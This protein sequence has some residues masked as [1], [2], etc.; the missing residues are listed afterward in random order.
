MSSNRN[1]IK[2]ANVS[3]W[4]IFALMTLT[5]FIMN[6]LFHYYAYG[7]LLFSSLWKE[8]LVFFEFYG[9]KFLIASALSSLV[10][11]FKRI[12]W[13]WLVV[14]IANVWIEANLLYFRNS[15]FFID[16]YS[17]LMAT[18]LQGYTSAASIY[19]QS[20]DWAFIVLT[21][22][23][24]L[25]TGL[26]N[27]ISPERKRLPWIALIIF[28]ISISLHSVLRYTQEKRLLDDDV[29]YR[30]N[31]FSHNTRKKT[32]QEIL[33]IKEHSILHAFFFDIVDLV[34][35]KKET[36]TL[37]EQDYQFIHQALGNTERG[38]EKA[39]RSLIVV[40]VE[41]FENW[42]L[43]ED[44]MPNLWQ[45]T[46]A[47]NVFYAPYAVSQIQQGTSSDGQLI[48]TTGLLPINEGATVFRFS[49]DSFPSFCQWYDKSI[50]VNPCGEIWNQKRMTNAYHYSDYVVWAEPQ[51]AYVIDS[52]ITLFSQ[53]SQ[54]SSMFVITSSTH[55]PF[56]VEGL[57]WTYPI[58]S[59][60][61]QTM[62]H[63]IQ[64]F[65]YLDESLKPLLDRVKNDAVFAN[66]VLV[67]AADHKVFDE[68]NRKQ[69]QNYCLKHDLALTPQEPFTPIIIYSPTLN[70]NTVYA[71]TAYQMDVFPTMQ[72]L[73]MDTIGSNWRGVGRNL[74]ST[75]THTHTHNLAEEEAYML[76]DKIIRGNYFK[77][78]DEN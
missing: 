13:T 44:I 8:P 17:L 35:L 48:V 62:A 66:A 47:E 33:L 15:G 56:T 32:Y 73:V 50:L 2:N 27:H 58:P 76:S 3:S 63:Y 70:G 29:E 31:V 61:P 38:A 24:V 54:P 60:M 46:H 41:S 67:I 51:D 21:C 23:Y 64:S 75:H 12:E 30:W 5:L 9:I 71:D 57:E 26:V 6:S 4:L 19:W 59:D 28:L 74:L 7:T 22:V 45:F 37:T 78:K 52:A 25:S 34:V 72:G 40:L 42:V 65:H 11:C 49:H 77:T 10:F 36:Y 53:A 14:I 68:D 18:N 20:R 55:A 43:T 16:T 1:I 69:F 39:Q